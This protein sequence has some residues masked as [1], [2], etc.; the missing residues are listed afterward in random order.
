MTKRIEADDG[1]IDLSDSV[2]NEVAGRAIDSDERFGQAF[3]EYVNENF[4]QSDSE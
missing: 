2:T 1:F 3:A 4:G